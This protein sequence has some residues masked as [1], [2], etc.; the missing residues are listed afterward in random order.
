MNFGRVTG[1]LSCHANS[2]K[3]SRLSRQTQHYAPLIK[4]WYLV[5]LRNCFISWYWDRKQMEAYCTII[6]DTLRKSWD[7][8]CFTRHWRGSRQVSST[9][10][11]AGCLSVVDRPWSLI[12]TV[13]GSRFSSARLRQAYRARI[14]RAHTVTCFLFCSLLYQPF[15]IVYKKI[16][17]WKKRRRKEERS[18]SKLH[19]FRRWGALPLCKCSRSNPITPLQ[20]RTS[21]KPFPP[22]LFQSP[23]RLI[24]RSNNK[25]GDT[26]F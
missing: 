8:H 17:P 24:T 1:H 19:Y 4:A 9:S 2:W 23:A 25:D 6:S 5:R 13:S 16:G 20:H 22:V 10:T 14:P 12:R 26:L 11:V 18:Q 3:L 15:L 21:L 7:K